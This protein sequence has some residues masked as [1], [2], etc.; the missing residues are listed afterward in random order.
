MWQRKDELLHRTYLY[1]GSTYIVLFF[2]SKFRQFHNLQVFST[3]GETIRCLL[4]SA[5]HVYESDLIHALF[6]SC[7]TLSTKDG[8]CVGS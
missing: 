6:D 8:E 2:K 1:I 7:L 5:A 4:R 3:V